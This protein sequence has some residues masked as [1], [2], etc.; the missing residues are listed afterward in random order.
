[1]SI[2]LSDTKDIVADMRLINNDYSEQDIQK[3][4]QKYLS[5]KYRLPST[6]YIIDYY[7]N[8][9]EVSEISKIYDVGT[10]TIYNAIKKMRIFIQRN[11]TYDIVDDSPFEGFL[12]SHD[13]GVLKQQTLE[14]IIIS[15]H[16]WEDV[17]LFL[18]RNRLL[19]SESEMEELLIKLAYY[20][21]GLGEKLFS[22]NKTEMISK[23]VEEIEKDIECKTLE[24]S[25]DSE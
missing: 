24:D 12:H 19:F 1:M 7:I 8:K 18:Y 20:V 23:R 5:I 15:Y 14:D 10:T 13:Y 9:K 22:Q 4:F 17:K 25:T 3:L 11:I 6:Q 2:Y 21:I 16:L